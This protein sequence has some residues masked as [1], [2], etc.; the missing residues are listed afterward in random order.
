[1]ASVHKASDVK[2]SFIDGS[3]K[4]SC[5]SLLYESLQR[6]KL[7]K[8]V[9][10]LKVL[11]LYDRL[12]SPVADSFRIIDEVSASIHRAADMVANSKFSDNERPFGIP[13]LNMDDQLGLT[14]VYYKP[15]MTIKHDKMVFT[16]VKNK[17]SS[18]HSYF[19]SYSFVYTIREL[20]K[21]DY[22]G[23]S[24]YSVRYSD[25]WLQKDQPSSGLNYKQIKWNEPDTLDGAKAEFVLQLK[26]PV[27]W[28]ESLARKL[29]A[30]LCDPLKNELLS[31]RR[32][33]DLTFLSFSSFVYLPDSST[34]L[35][36]YTLANVI[37]CSFSYISEIPIQSP[38]LLPELIQV[39][40]ANVLMVSLLTNLLNLIKERQT[41]DDDIEFSF[42]DVLMEADR[43]EDLPSVN[44]NVNINLVQEEFVTSSFIL[45]CLAIEMEANAN[46]LKVIPKISDS[47][48][49][50]LEGTLIQGV[51]PDEQLTKINRALNLGDIRIASILFLQ[52]S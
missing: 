45:T 46:V 13:L 16:G 36:N 38:S 14:I 41:N 31:Y 52:R 24:K 43:L 18:H 51:L 10:C 50:Y 22:V 40:R 20:P 47:G 34:Q 4:K 25:E 15:V 2:Y 17:S 19:S 7:D 32:L 44:K 21:L 9:Q 37:P 39:L 29:D 12:S 5:N 27:L 48:A 42:A 26:S 33:R 28:P 30:T 1:M 8:F 11:A 6:P 3:L 23:T 49:V 35:L